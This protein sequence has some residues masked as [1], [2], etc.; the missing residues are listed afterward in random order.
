[1]QN[2]WAE[3]EANINF[4]KSWKCKWKFGCFPGPRLHSYIVKSF[5]PLLHQTNMHVRGKTGL[6]VLTT[7]MPLG[8]QEHGFCNNTSRAE[9]FHRQK[10]LEPER[11]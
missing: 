7:Q 5:L 8:P 3:H 6:H 1:M 11:I 4:H 10:R 2:P 9:S